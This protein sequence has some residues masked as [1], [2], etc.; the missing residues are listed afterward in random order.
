MDTHGRFEAERRANRAL[1]RVK[2]ASGKLQLEGIGVTGR[3]E[4][5][6]LTSIGGN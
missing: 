2:S 4:F 3:F 1:F 5:Q 6:G